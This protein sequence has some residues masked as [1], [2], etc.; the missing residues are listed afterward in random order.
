MSR[1]QNS[2]FPSRSAW[3]R[4]AAALVAVLSIVVPSG[5]AAA[6]CWTPPVTG[7]VTDPFRAPACRWCPGNRGIEYRT[8]GLRTVRAVAAGTVVFSGVVA[9]TRYVVVRLGNGWLV[10]YGRLA[11]TGLR[12]GATV[13]GRGV[14]GTTA[15]ELFFGLRIAGAYVDPAQYLGEL[16]GRPRLV[17]L[18]STAARSVTGHVRRCLR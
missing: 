5:A 16:V 18:D 17:P 9:G 2:T 8:S 13:A 4:G 1:V 7:W 6:P 10:T 3:R 11:S 15:R 12:R 14:V